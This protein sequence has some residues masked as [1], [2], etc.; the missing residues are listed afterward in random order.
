MYRVFSTEEIAEM[1]EEWYHTPQWRHKRA[2]ILRRD[3]YEC[4]RC[5]RVHHRYGKATTVHHIQHLDAHP[6]LAVTDSNLISLC[7][8][9]HNEVHPEKSEKIRTEKKWQDEKW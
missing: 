2:E 9:C 7:A 3:H 1:K 4:Q 6:E 8:N 5:R